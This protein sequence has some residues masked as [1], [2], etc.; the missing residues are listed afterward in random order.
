MIAYKYAYICMIAFK[1]TPKCFW[2]EPY[3]TSE[4]RTSFYL[5]KKITWLYK[6]ISLNKHIPMQKAPNWRDQQRKF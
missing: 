4:E 6:H 1:I 2:R 5:S 3:E